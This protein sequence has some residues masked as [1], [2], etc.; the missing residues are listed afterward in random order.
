MGSA[1]VARRASTIGVWMGPGAMA[2]QR[3]PRGAH[4][5]ASTFASMWTPALATL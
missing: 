1:L 3:I 2:L 5:R 4:S